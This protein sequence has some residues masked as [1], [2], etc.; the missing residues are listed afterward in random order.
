[1]ADEKNP[2]QRFFEAVLKARQGNSSAAITLLTEAVQFGFDDFSRIE[3]HPDLQ[4][5][6]GKEGYPEIFATQKILQP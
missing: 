1:M 5:L 2:E 4:N 6:R 3:N